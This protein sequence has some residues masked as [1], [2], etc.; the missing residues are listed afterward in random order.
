MASCP[1]GQRRRTGRR[2]QLDGPCNREAKSLV[3][4][5]HALGRGAPLAARALHLRRMTVMD[6]AVRVLIRPR[7]YWG[8]SVPWTVFP[9]K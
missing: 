2:L 9:K 3:C 6:D 5:R 4:Q 7:E 1:Q 8:H